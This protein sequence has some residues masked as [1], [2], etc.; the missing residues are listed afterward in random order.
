MNKLLLSCF[1]AL[2]L[3]FAGGEAMALELSSPVFEEAAPIPERFTGKGM[4][5][6]PPLAWSGAPSHT[7][8]FA[9]ICDDPDAPG[10]IWVHWVIYNIPSSAKSLKEKITKKEELNDGTRQ[11]TNSFRKI[12]YG[13][14]MPPPGSPHRYVFKLYALDK[15]LDLKPGASKKE[16]LNAMKGRILQKT[17]IYGT[18]K[19]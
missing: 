2:T 18:F 3:I 6:S 19:R 9:V 10:M 14:P 11:G 1:I 15:K 13:G 17:Q 4:D 5:I 7:K 8:A 12:G 16:L